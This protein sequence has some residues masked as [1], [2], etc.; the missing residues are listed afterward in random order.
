[1]K[2][3]RKIIKRLISLSIA[4]VSV[5]TIQTFALDNI[6]TGP[7]LSN[8]PHIYIQCF[9]VQTLGLK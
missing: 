4:T 3:C 7:M 2:S 5:L 1:M 6:S 8:E 9:L